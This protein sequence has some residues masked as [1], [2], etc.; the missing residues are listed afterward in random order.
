LIEIM[1]NDDRYEIISAILKCSKIDEWEDTFVVRC[2]RW[3]CEI[4]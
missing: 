1:E 2:C 4:E 3:I